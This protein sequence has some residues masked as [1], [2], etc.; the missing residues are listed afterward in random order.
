MAKQKFTAEELDY[1]ERF[2]VRDDEE[3]MSLTESDE[4]AAGKPDHFSKTTLQRIE[5]WKVFLALNPIPEKFLPKR[6]EV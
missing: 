6:K 3:T 2:R 1:L 5:E 4:S